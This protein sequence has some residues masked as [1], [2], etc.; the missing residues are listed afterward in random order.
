MTVRRHGD[1]KEP[2]EEWSRCSGQ[3]EDAS[4]PTANQV[5][6]AFLV[7]AG[8]DPEGLLWRASHLGLTQ[9]TS[10][11]AARQPLPHHCS[12]SVGLLPTQV[13][14]GPFLKHHTQIAAHLE[15]IVFF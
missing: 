11:Q 15:R 6:E 12:A 13:P 1:H 4:A 2:P 5:G 10:L 3:L 9:L 14:R 7:A 8:R